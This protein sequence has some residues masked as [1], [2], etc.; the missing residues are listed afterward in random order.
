MVKLES[1]FSVPAPNLRLAGW[2]MR[3]R[4]DEL[5]ALPSGA[6]A[7]SAKNEMASKCSR[8]LA[9]PMMEGRIEAK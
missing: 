3:F 9:R 4:L 6:A 2:G 1:I 8:P 5:C 7:S